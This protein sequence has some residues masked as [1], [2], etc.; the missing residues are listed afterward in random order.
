MNYIII[1]SEIQVSG[2]FFSGMVE[3][4]EMLLALGA[5]VTV[6]DT[7]GKFYLSLKICN[8]LIRTHYTNQRTH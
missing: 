5:S 8:T 4:T 7:L 1:L 2:N 6:C 3:A